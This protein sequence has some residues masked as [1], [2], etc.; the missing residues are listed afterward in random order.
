MA[1]DAIEVAAAAEHDRVAPP[2][3]I[4]TNMR[5]QPACMIATCILRGSE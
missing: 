1:G 3:S 2:T 5:S 4:A